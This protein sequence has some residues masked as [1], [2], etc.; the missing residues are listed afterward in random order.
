ML[1][2]QRIFIQALINVSNYI[3][4]SDEE[5]KDQ[6]KFQYLNQIIQ[7]MTINF[8][9]I[10]QKPDFLK[11][12]QNSTI[13]LDIS[14]HL[15]QFRGIIRSNVIINN[16]I[17]GFTS[18]YFKYFVQLFKIYENIPEIKL[19]ILKLYQDFTEI[20]AENLEENQWKDLLSSI[21][22]IFQNYSCNDSRKVYN[23][24]L[25]D[26]QKYKD[27][28]TLLK[29]LYNLTIQINNIEDIQNT[30]FIGISLIL[31][32]IDQSLLQVYL[33]LIFY[34]LKFCISFQNFLK[35]ILHY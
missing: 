2:I 22:Y 9:S 23:N 10:L 26:E 3:H 28:I 16:I 15:E 32:Y 13:L 18:D 4:S 19:I 20:Q 35:I 31:P 14:K 30:I 5:S 1:D 34:F 7:P 29:I 25:N 11:N 17:Y 24:H 12:Y 8:I 6:L 21:I 27:I 33:L